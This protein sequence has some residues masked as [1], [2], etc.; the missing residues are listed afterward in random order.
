MRF[1]LSSTFIALV[2]AHCSGSTA[3][4]D[5][6]LSDATIDVA[7]D[8]TPSDAAPSDALDD[9]ATDADASVAGYCALY[10]Q[11][12]TTCGNTDTCFQ[13]REAACPT[14]IVNYSSQFLSAYASCESKW[15]CPEGGVDTG[16]G[17]A[18]RQCVSGKLTA[19]GTALQLA[20]DVCNSCV[21]PS[22]LTQC[23]QNFYTNLGVELLDYDDTVLSDV[24]STCGVF[25][26]GVGDAGAC[27]TTFTDCATKVVRK[28]VPEPA[29]CNDN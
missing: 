3:T 27:V 10:T 18:F 11:N 19:D 17:A 14:D 4:T 25:D 9:S 8:V 29:A 15:A 23:E 28:H 26:A 1:A 24:D 16:G 5:G 20:Q 6:G 12:E 2:L 21:D 13:A 7:D 22:K